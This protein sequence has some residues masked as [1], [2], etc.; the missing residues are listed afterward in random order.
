MRCH[1]CSY[2]FTLPQSIAESIPPGPSASPRQ[3]LGVVLGLGLLTAIFFN[4]YFF[5]GWLFLILT[6]YS[7]FSWIRCYMGWLSNLNPYSN[8]PAGT[9]PQCG[10]KNS[11]F[12]WSH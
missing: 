7:F 8:Q 3:V 10:I 1:N 9:C 4:L 6:A 11:I 12:P 2:H 5:L